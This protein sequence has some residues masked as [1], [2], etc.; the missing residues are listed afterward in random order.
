MKSKRGRC[1][2]LQ[3]CG[4]KDCLLGAPPH[5]PTSPGY[6]HL[7]LVPVNA[8]HVRKKNGTAG[9]LGAEWFRLYELTMFSKHWW[10]WITKWGIFVRARERSS[11]GLKHSVTTCLACRW[12]HYRRVYSVKTHL[13]FRITPHL[14]GCCVFRQQADVWQIPSDWISS[15]NLETTQKGDTQ[16]VLRAHNNSFFQSF[17]SSV[18]LSRPTWKGSKNWKKMKQV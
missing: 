13:I 5:S 9:G 10:N 12:C 1:V 16:P 3:D 4:A 7:G 6:S 11:F 8:N 18:Q 2:F 15:T 17:I 14:K